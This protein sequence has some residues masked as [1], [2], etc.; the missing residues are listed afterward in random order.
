MVISHEGNKNFSVYH[1]KKQHIKKSRIDFDKV[2]DDLG[3]LQVKLNKAFSMIKSLK[4]SDWIND[5]NYVIII[6]EPDGAIFP[7]SVHV[8]ERKWYNGKERAKQHVRSAWRA[9]KRAVKSKIL[10]SKV[11]GY[12]VVCIGNYTKSV[13]GSGCRKRMRI[14]KRLVRG[15]VF[16]YKTTFNWVQ[17]VIR[18]LKKMFQAR[19]EGF[20]IKIDIRTATGVYKQI[21][22]WLKDVNFAFCNISFYSE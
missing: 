22:E 10:L 9:W 12:L 15:G 20:K 8:S 21:Y 11:R 1:Y 5:K 13:K 7:V 19:L 14:G 4:F 3:Y 18:S 6:E 17:H 2:F 16:I